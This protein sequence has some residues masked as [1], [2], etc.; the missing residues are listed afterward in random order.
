MLSRC[1]LVLIQCPRSIKH[2]KLGR[3][4]LR[5]N[6]FG[7]WWRETTFFPKLSHVTLGCDQN[8]F[9]IYMC[10][11]IYVHTHIYIY[12]HIIY[13]YIYTHRHYLYCIYSLWYEHACVYV[14]LYA[15]TYVS[16]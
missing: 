1:M 3:L 2:K 10:I 16:M 11:Y 7:A 6:A 9:Y 15:R 8:F 12:I 13:I 14:C 5:P 4:Y